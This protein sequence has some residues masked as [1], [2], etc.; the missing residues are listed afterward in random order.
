MMLVRKG[1]VRVSRLPFTSLTSK[2][3]A[4]GILVETVSERNSSKCCSTCGK[5]GSR[6]KRVLFKCTNKQ[7]SEYNQPVNADLNGARNIL[8]RYLQLGLTA[9]KVLVGSLAIPMIK[10]WNFHTWNSHKWKL[11]NHVS[12]SLRN[13]RPDNIPLVNPLPCRQRRTS[14]LIK[15]E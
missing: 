7:C 1:L 13:Q 3:E 5:K 11:R 9:W 4:V 2:A 12:S 15:K 10:R 14:I 6:C 8:N